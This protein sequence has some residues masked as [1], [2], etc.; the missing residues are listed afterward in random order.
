MI[1]IKEQIKYLAQRVN[2]PAGI[3]KCVGAK[4]A[5]YTKVKFFFLSATAKTQL[6]LSRNF[7]TSLVF[8]FVEIFS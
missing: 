7:Q 3:L 2:E 8:L 6:R 5:P 4:L 1:S